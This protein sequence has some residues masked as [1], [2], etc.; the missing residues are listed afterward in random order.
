MITDD[1][2]Y[3]PIELQASIADLQAAGASDDHLNQLIARMLA[4]SEA[5]T[6]DLQL[7][8]GR[9]HDSIKQQIKRLGDALRGDLRTERGET[10]GMLVDLRQAIEE[11]GRGIADLKKQWQELGEWRS[12]VEAALLGI[13]EFRDESTKDRRDLRETVAQQDKRHGRQIEEIIDQLAD[14]A[15]QLRQFGLRL[16][17]I[18]Q[19][20]RLAGE[21]TEAGG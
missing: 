6:T 8:L 17:E 9:I 10:N 21:H 19:H 7:G 16:A 14:F 1:I 18:E 20:Q 5:K 4:A 13:S 2:Q 3:L 11:A 12:R 15:G